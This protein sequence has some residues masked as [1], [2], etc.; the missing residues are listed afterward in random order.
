MSEHAADI[1]A[2]A[3]ALAKGL[4]EAPSEVSVEI[5]EEDSREMVLELIVAEP[6]M[7]RVIGK[8]GRTVRALRNVL[9]A[10]AEKQGKHLEL[11]IVE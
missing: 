9:A 6:D 1:R 7:G 5:V 2:L 4:T 8:G 10:A 11:D 3:E